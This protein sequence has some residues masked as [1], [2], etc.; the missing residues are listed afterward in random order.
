MLI[1]HNCCISL[2]IYIYYLFTGGPGWVT[3]SAAEM[4]GPVGCIRRALIDCLR[5]RPKL[6]EEVGQKDIYPLVNSYIT[7]ENHRFQW[8]NPLLNDHVQ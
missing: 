8:V 6:L 5:H 2:S 1:F 4:L 3:L 7:M